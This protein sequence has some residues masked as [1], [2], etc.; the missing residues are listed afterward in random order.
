MG[1]SCTFIL[2]PFVF[3]IGNVLKQ[4]YN[5][6]STAI[7]RP[8]WKK[9][10]QAELG[11]YQMASSYTAIYPIAC[12]FNLSDAGCPGLMYPALGRSEPQASAQ[13]PQVLPAQDFPFLG[14][15]TSQ[16][17]LVNLFTP[18]PIF[19]LKVR[20]LRR[21]FSVGQHEHLSHSPMGGLFRV[22][23]KMLTPW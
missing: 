6:C 12:H 13:H 19:L 11:L 15:S 20:K 5:A 10:S 8:F 18:D 22:W 4:M 17:Y 21:H 7:V 1:G 9:Q 23:V 16:F 3:A 14:H 2:R